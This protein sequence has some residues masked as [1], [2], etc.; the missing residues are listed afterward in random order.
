MTPPRCPTGERHE[1][2]QAATDHDKVTATIT[3]PQRLDHQ[4]KQRDNDHDLVDEMI[5]RRRPESES[6]NRQRAQKDSQ[7]VASNFAP[8]IKKSGC[9]EK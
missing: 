1:N 3:I 6:R 7:N 2:E 4:Q 9:M 5:R 8:A